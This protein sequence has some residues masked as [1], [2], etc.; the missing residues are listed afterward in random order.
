MLVLS[1]VVF[2]GSLWIG[3]YFLTTIPANYFSHR[4]QPLAAFRASHPAVRWTLLI[5][6]NLFGVVFIVAGVI[7]FFTPGQGILTLLL[8]LALSMCPANSAS[9]AGLFSVPP[10]SRP[11]TACVA[12]PIS[13]RWNSTNTTAVTRRK[14]QDRLTYG[15]SL[16]LRVFLAAARKSGGQRH[17]PAF[18][19][20]HRPVRRRG[21]TAWSDTHVAN[22]RIGAQVVRRH[23]PSRF[24]SYRRIGAGRHEPGRSDA[25]AGR[26]REFPCGAA[27]VVR[28]RQVDHSHPPVRLAQPD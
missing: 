11:S 17:L 16:M 10:C 28:P 12:G 6:K 5:A 3:H 19:T 4:H 9:C 15:R 1:L 27:Q 14:P 21:P 22:P 24:A 2:V 7:M 13:P 20:P 23:D 25:M 18:R 8:G 26:G